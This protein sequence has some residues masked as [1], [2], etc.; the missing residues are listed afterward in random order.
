[1]NTQSKSDFGKY[2]DNLKWF[3]AGGVSLIPGIGLFTDYSPPLIPDG[4]VFSVAVSMAII[5]G[6]FLLAPRITVASVRLPQKM[7]RKA[8]GLIGVAVVLYVVYASFLGYCTVLEPQ[9]YSQRFQIGFGK[10]DWSLTP[11]GVELKYG[12]PSATLEDWMMM[13]GAFRQGGPDII[14]KTWTINAAGFLLVMIYLVSFVLWTLGFSNLA[15][16]MSKKGIQATSVEKPD[17][18][19]TT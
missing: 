7:T 18:V 15:V 2:I 19:T 14:W 8:W 5:C 17:E 4:K 12:N 1:M 3:G 10:S 16:I 6:C 9:N 11:E 13:E